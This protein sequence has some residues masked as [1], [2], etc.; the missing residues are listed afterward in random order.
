[1][2]VTAALNEHIEDEA[3]LVDRAPESMLDTGDPNFNL[4]EVPFF[5][6]ARQPSPDPIRDLL[7]ELQRPLTHGLVA[8]D[9]AAGCEQLFDHVQAQWEAKVQPHRVADDRG[10]KPV[11]SEALAIRHHAGR[12][13]DPAPSRKAST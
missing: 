2:P 4:V 9:D 12:L 13:R 3:G 8:V 10:R 6:D 5:A 11:T 7:A 1:V